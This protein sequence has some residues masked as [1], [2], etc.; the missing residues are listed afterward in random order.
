MDVKGF[1][2][3]SFFIF[4]QKTLDNRRGLWYYIYVKRKENLHK[5]ERGQSM[6][7]IYEIKAIKDDGY[8]HGHIGVV[9]RMYTTKD[10]AEKI[11]KALPDEI[12][13]KW[14]REWWMHYTEGENN[15]PTVWV[16]ELEVEGL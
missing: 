5:P 4:F 1:L 8:G 10:E 14:P 7:K 3:K 6:K 16:E 11:A 12:I 13:A 9:R 15:K 2:K